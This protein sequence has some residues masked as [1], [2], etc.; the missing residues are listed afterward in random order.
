[1][2]T[3]GYCSLV[4]LTLF[5]LWHAKLTASVEENTGWSSQFQNSKVF[6]ENKGQFMPY[7]TTEKTLFAI[8]NGSTMIYFSAKGVSYSFLKRSKK[9]E[10]ENERERNIE[11]FKNG[12]THSEIEAEERKME[13]ARD[14]VFFYWENSN[15]EVEVVPSEE[16]LDYYS[17]AIKEK[18]GAVKNINHIK[19]FKKLTYKNIYPLIDIEYVFH[20]T[21]GLKYSLILHP[22]ADIS[23]VKMNYNSKIKMKING[24]LHFPTLFGDIIEHA[25]H[26]F[27][28]ENKLN[29]ISS[30]FVKKGSSISFN[31]GAFDHSKT[32]IIDPWVQTP[33]LSNSNCVW[34]CE[35]DGGGNAYIIGG[36]MPMKLVKYSPTGSLL[37]TY[38]TPWD[39]SDNWLGTL[40]TDLAG[41][42][43]ITSGS[44]AAL[45][46]IN[47]GGAMVY[48]V[49]GGAMDEYWTISFNCDQTK[50]IVGGTRLNGIPNITGDG[51]I[52]D[53][54]TSN[55]S[56]SA[57]K[58]VGKTRTHLVFGFSVTDVEEVRS[59]TPSRGAKYYFL[60]LDSIGAISQDFSACPG[61]KP[62][63]NINHGYNWGYK[64]E[65]YRPENGNSGVKCIK[66]NGNFVYTQNGTALH[67]RSL[68]TGAILATVTIAGGL[69]TLNA[70]VNQ[71]GNGGIDID[72]C[73]NLYVGSGNALIKYDANLN[74]ISSTTLPYR[75]FDV[76]VSY[77]GNVI[78]VGA[79]GDNTSATRTGYVQSVNMSSC[80]PMTL[81]CCDATICP[82]G[83]LCTSDAPITLIP[84]TPGG[85]WSGTGVNSSSGVFSPSV[86]GAG[87]FTLIY[88]LACGSD[89]TSIIVECCGAII[90]PSGPF[91]IGD[92]PVNLTAVTAGGTWAGTGIT[93]ASVGTF[94]PAIAGAGTHSISY[95]I[96]GC[97]SDILNI[98]VASCV[99]LTACKETNG[100]ITATSGTA[101]FTWYSQS[102]SQDCSA[103]AFACFPPGCE[104]NVVSWTSF[105]TG[106][107]IIPPGTYPIMVI[108]ASGDSLQINNIS[109][110]PDCS[111]S[112]PALSLN[113]LNIINDSC[114]GQSSGSFDASTSGG[115]SP[116]DYTL[117]N[118]SGA[119]VATFINVAGTQSFTGL[120]AGSYT[121]NVV[122]N[123]NCPG[124]NTLT[125]TEPVAATTIA[126]AG[127]D[128]TL[129]S[130]AAT[131][132]GN[133]PSVGAGI[134]T[135]VSGAGTITAPSSEVSGIT[136]LG[137]GANVFQWTISNSP[138]QPTNDQVT[139]TNTG[140]GNP[141]A[142]GPDQ[143]ICS[144]S[145][146]LGAS[147]PTQGTGSWTLLSGTGTITAPSSPTSGVTGLGIGTIIFEWTTSNPPCPSSSDQI[148]ITNTGGGPLVAISSQTNVTCYAG[149]NG[150]ATATASGGAGSLIYLWTP[151]GG[152]ALT[153]NNLT[154]GTY[155][156]SATDV[157]GCVGIETIVISQPDSIAA[158]L[159]ITAASCGSADGTASVLA[160]GGSG[161]LSYLWTPGAVT[162]ASIGPLAAGSYT[163]TITDS[164]GCTETIPAIVS[165]AGGPTASV[166]SSTTINAGSSILL[167][168]GGGVTYLWTPTIGL[169]C[170]TC[171]NTIAS[172]NETTLYCV[173]VSDNNGCTD[174][175]CLTIT[176]IDSI[177]I[178]ACGT[179][180]VPNSF[181]PKNN[182]LVND[183]FKPITTCISN[184]MFLIFNKWGEK[185]F[186]TQNTT[187]G[188]NGYFK[189]ELCKS[190]V[191]IYKIFYVNDTNNESYQ[192]YGHLTL[193]R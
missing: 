75:V 150:S 120:P 186:E 61:A 122:D 54:N 24:D 103:C 145:T 1:M 110:L 3:N 78:V 154:A 37:W 33:S 149:N 123:I 104:V 48:S 46:K 190:D 96:N 128:Q 4:I 107:T 82:A 94:S 148:T 114:F 58:V 133:A 137:A 160:S 169:D 188:W 29:V 102:T 175:A 179:V 9:K 31:L 67:K 152:L 113:I 16:T 136:N 63:F 30:N 6:I 158:S 60:T 141:A 112:C 28:S 90:N 162:T 69:N 165:S 193:L 177:S 81:F 189:G 22:G 20:P 180:F 174:T 98:S 11:D 35:K 74:M 151:T 76:S 91:C 84:V 181:S 187:E 157:N 5:F 163:L 14:L 170:D 8:D 131:L 142:A 109:S 101:P 70:G 38:S 168:S 21:D 32:I 52:F 41:N 39:T 184:Y 164:L 79:T 129:C 143:S 161:G 72:S 127:A 153:A 191:Y 12:K 62:L 124:T 89:S 140:G 156:I 36:D 2:K 34:E 7:K 167:T 138:C 18:D 126:L 87:T 45:Q 178:P 183:E 147:A 176:V 64:C 118:G 65:K 17:Y 99:T 42:S 121:L 185:I 71:A 86:A 15:P 88:T 73:G 166:I 111:N 56:V 51:V 159:S 59:M 44:D 172:P 173:T 80:N 116:W 10:K 117:L 92:A 85:T 47:S 23:K 40:A 139:I 108:D 93:N 105:T 26:T 132:S 95:S 27:Y 182:D 49:L 134:W 68:S 192:I 135:L 66:A 13:F 155:S 97:G 171:R 125:I 19:A 55:G 77:G 50:L 43:Y 119:T 83:P 144:S 53:I 130:N 115:A 57:V 25:P 100:G 146:I 106:I